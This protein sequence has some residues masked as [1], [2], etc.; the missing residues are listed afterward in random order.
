MMPLTMAT[1]GE[2]VKLVAIHGGRRVRQRLADLGL[3]P[4]TTLHVVRADSWGPLI[5]A[6]KDDARLA[7][8][9][10]MA[11]KIEVEPVEAYKHK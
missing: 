7:L 9:R 8:G 1:P 6:F 3:T 10:G 11:H 4:G 2:A 5:V